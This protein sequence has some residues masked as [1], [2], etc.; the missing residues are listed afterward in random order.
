MNGCA[1]LLLDY[2]MNENQK[3]LEKNT[4]MPKL[5]KCVFRN[6]NLEGIDF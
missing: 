2:N 5:I 4:L 6:E 3:A 1:I